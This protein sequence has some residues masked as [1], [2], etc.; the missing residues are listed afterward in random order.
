MIIV[1]QEGGRGTTPKNIVIETVSKTD[2]ESEELYLDHIRQTI[3]EQ[4][5]VDAHVDITYAYGYD[6]NR[7]PLPTILN[8]L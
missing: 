5:W 7:Y 4:L 6:I 3:R 1:Y 2:F 8:I